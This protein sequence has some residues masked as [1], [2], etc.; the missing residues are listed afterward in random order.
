VRSAVRLSRAPLRGSVSLRGISSG[1]EVCRR[2]RG[3][4]LTLDVG[5][6]SSSGIRSAEQDTVQ[7][8][9]L[10][11]GSGTRPDAR[12]TVAPSNYTTRK[13]ETMDASRELRRAVLLV[14]NKTLHIQYYIS[15]RFSK[16]NDVGSTVADPLMIN[17]VSII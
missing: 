6:R 16:Y 7:D 10:T 8:N 5:T 15:T 1:S 11:V 14:H 4:A 2:N 13:G 3:Q 17:P 12:V 9:G